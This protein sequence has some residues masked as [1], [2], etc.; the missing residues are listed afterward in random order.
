MRLPIIA[1]HKSCIS[2]DLAAEAAYASS[3]DQKEFALFTP[4]DMVRQLLA[5]R[6]PAKAASRLPNAAPFASRHIPSLLALLTAFC[7]CALALGEVG[8]V[9]PI[10]LILHMFK[11]R[12]LDAGVVQS[13]RPLGQADPLLYLLAD[14]VQLR[15]GERISLY[16]G[17]HQHGGHTDSR[18]LVIM[19]RD[20]RVSRARLRLPTIQCSLDAKYGFDGGRHAQLLCLLHQARVGS[21]DW[22]IIRSLLTR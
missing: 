9:L 17:A 14:L 19:Q 8:S 22:I 2:A 13:F 7:D 3:D 21:F 16:V 20:T 1:F 5:K 15:S 18:F 10:V 6:K 4:E 11:G 12:G